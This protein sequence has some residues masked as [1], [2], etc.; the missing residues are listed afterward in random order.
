MLFLSNSKKSGFIE[1]YLRIYLEKEISIK[2]IYTSAEDFLQILHL[3]DNVRLISYNS[4]LFSQSTGLFDE[5]SNIFGLGNPDQL[6]LEL[7]FHKASKTASFIDKFLN[8]K[9]RIAKCE[10]DNLICV[11]RD[12][13]NMEIIFNTDSFANRIDVKAEQ[14]NNGMFNDQYVEEAL[15]NKIGL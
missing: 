6:S 8:W 2:K 11:G 13:K 12:D 15:A 1:E 14:N 10:L 3:I 9:N 5:S 7:K 4:D